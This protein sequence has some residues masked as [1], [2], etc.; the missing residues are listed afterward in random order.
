MKLIQ[1]TADECTLRNDDDADVYHVAITGDVTTDINVPELQPGQV[2]QFSL[3]PPSQRRSG[4][5]QVRW[6]THLGEKQVLTQQ[7]H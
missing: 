5:L 4:Q 7:L 2:I 1:N 3:P 6:E